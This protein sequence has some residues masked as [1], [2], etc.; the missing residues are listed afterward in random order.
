MPMLVIALQCHCKLYL[1]NVTEHARTK[2]PISNCA[3]VKG[4][5]MWRPYFESY[6]SQFDELQISNPIQHSEKIDRL[7]LT[8]NFG[9]DCEA[10][11]KVAATM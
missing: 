2:L 7:D 3:G 8:H 6:H 5:G 10:P 11:L 4:A 9:L 1:S